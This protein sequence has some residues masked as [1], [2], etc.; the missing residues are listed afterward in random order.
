MMIDPSTASAIID[1]DAYQANIAAIQELIGD[2]QLMC[3]VKADGYGHGMLA[4]AHA[5]RAAGVPWLGA[6]T[7]L[8]ALALREDGDQ[9]RLLTWLY[10]P[11]EDLTALV[12]ASIDIGAHSLAD[13]SRLVAAAG[14]AE[15]LAR[16]H[17]K[18]DTGLTRNG[19]QPADWPDLCAAAA[20]AEAAGAI[21]VAGVW[22]HLAASDELGDP[23]VDRQLKV[24]ESAL[25]IASEVG[26]RPEVRHLANSAGALVVPKSHYDLVRVGIASYGIDP[27]PGIVATA[28]ITL[29]PVMTLRAQLVA[30]KPIDAGEGVSYGHTWVSDRPTTVGLVPLGYADG[31]PRQASNMASAAVAG[32]LAPIRGTVC[33]DQFMVDLGPAS[34]ARPGDEVILF[35]GRPDTGAGTPEAGSPEAAAGA[36][37]AGA[38]G[39][40]ALVTAEDWAAA[41]HTIGYEIVTRIGTRVPRVYPDHIH[42]SA[43]VQR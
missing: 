39:A 32:R 3:V 22:S 12:A 9:G 17:L 36:S 40:G 37:Q 13:V 19:A 25:A 35:G 18:I 33:M 23:S 20:E 2:S 21:T 11:D 31:I 38:T 16:V 26:L 29:R 10:G 15:R 43:G 5:A 34:T 30:V 7:P 41:C 42:R 27:A 6:A 14:T 4:C 24:F 28:G 1:L 8:E